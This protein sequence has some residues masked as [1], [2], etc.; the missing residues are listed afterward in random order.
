MYRGSILTCDFVN[1]ARLIKI[2]GSDDFKLNTFQYYLWKDFQV[3][4][5]YKVH[6]F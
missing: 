3:D 2:A 6:L 5:L 1:A 4:F